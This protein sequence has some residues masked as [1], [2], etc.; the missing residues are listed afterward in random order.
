MIN[1]FVTLHAI[2][3]RCW[4]SV[5]FYHWVFFLNYNFLS[6]FFL[7]ILSQRACVCVSVCVRVCMCVFAGWEDRQVWGGKWGTKQPQ[8]HIFSTRKREK[9]SNVMRIV[10][11]SYFPAHLPPSPIHFFFQFPLSLSLSSSISPTTFCF[12]FSVY[13]FLDYQKKLNDSEYRGHIWSSLRF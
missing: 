1:S 8:R 6:F 3:R 2:L 11:P 13:F 9:I 7:K 10:L 12:V 5:P 4:M